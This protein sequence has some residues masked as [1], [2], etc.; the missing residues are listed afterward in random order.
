MLT[1]LTGRDNK[2][3]RTP[4]SKVTHFD[5]RLADTV[6]MMI[7]TM[8]N[9]DGQDVTGIGIAAPQVGIAKNIIIVTL[10]LNNKKEPKVLAMINP[11]IIETSENFS[12]YEEGCLSLPGA[13]GR[14]KRP[15]K[16]KV[17][18]QNVDGNWCEKKL[19]KWDAR[20]FLHE[21]DHL[22]GKLFI[23]YL[24]EKEIARLT[25]QGHL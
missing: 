7:D 24:D 13:Y 12:N 11:E 23:D 6:E 15:A 10:N 19:D 16:I 3:L 21:Y 8:L 18:W 2:I 22:I 20:I 9:P 4:A 17:K 1:I 14:V 25:K 5:T